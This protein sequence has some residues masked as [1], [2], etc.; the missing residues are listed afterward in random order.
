MKDK[1]TRRSARFCVAF[2]AAY[3][4][5]SAP[6]CA[7]SP[8]SDDAFELLLK[9][10]EYILSDDGNDKTAAV[11]LE[12][13]VVL[14]PAS[15]EGAPQPET[16]Y[17]GPH[18]YVQ[19]NA[20]RSFMFGA[21]I[22]RITCRPGMLTDVELEPGERVVNVAV[23]DPDRWSVSAAWNGALDN[24]VTHVLLKTQFPG[25]RTSLMIYT[26]RRTYSIEISSD[27]EAPHVPYVGFSYKPEGFSYK[28]DGLGGAGPLSDE[29]P[30]LI[31]GS[32]IYSRYLIRAASDSDGKKISW[33]PVL[34]YDAH[35]KTYIIMPKDMKMTPGSHSLSIK[36][37]DRDLLV[38]YKVLKKDLYVVNR[39]FNVA[40]LAFG[41]EKIELRRKDRIEL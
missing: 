34:V 9:R 39:T 32:D 37:G 15:Q 38:T 12:E 2:F 24:L 1:F 33:T 23:S 27:T 25:M 19:N 4:L 21:G 13:S 8:V 7:A 31:N 5:A 6:V 28:P 11:V 18:Q 30:R 3:F 26:D 36:Q 35:G 10:Y 17:I 20:K 14:P 41:G 40:V 29:T 22:P 16:A